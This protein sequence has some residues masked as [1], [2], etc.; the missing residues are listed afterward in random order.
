MG[1][2][3]VKESEM[4]TSVPFSLTYDSDR[5]RKVKVISLFTAILLFLCSR[6]QNVTAFYLSVEIVIPHP[7]IN[8]FDLRTESVIKS[9]NLT[10]LRGSRVRFP[11]GAG[12]FSLHHR[13]QNGSGAY[14]ASY[15]MG[16]RG[17]FPGRKAAGA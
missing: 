6:P 17:S 8:L 12:N 2:V 5:P 1:P 14:P 13:A 11:A 4:S 16:I 15:P 3:I 9:L 7:H 10:L